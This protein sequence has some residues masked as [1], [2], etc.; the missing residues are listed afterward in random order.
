M[1]HLS[2]FSFKD[3]LGIAAIGLIIFATIKA[4]CKPGNGKGGNGGSGN[5]N[6]TPSK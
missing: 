3:I 2:A 6:N 5:N 1:F 4:M